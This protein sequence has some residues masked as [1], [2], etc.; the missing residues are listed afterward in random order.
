M[1]SVWKIL[2]LLGVFIGGGLFVSPVMA[3][4]YDT[5]L[6]AYDKWIAEDYRYQI[7]DIEPDDV[8]SGGIADPELYDGV[9]NVTDFSDDGNFDPLGAIFGVFRWIGESVAS[10]FG[11][12]ISDP[13][14]AEP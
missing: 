10:I 1:N 6:I 2:F 8:K 4:R 11:A 5:S 12:E 7:P 3:R 9:L 14:E 13:Y